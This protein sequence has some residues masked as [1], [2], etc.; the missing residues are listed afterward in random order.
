MLCLKIPG[1]VANSVDPDDSAASHLGLHC[2]LL[3]DCLN[4]YDKYEITDCL[5]V[6]TT[7]LHGYYDSLLADLL[8]KH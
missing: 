8:I 5:E 3:P 2:L 4:T 1:C 7:H 6:F